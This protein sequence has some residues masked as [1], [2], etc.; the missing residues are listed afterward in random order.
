MFVKNANVLGICAWAQQFVLAQ[1]IMMLAAVVLNPPEFP[2][3]FKS[4]SHGFF[5][6]LFLFRILVFLKI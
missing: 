3:S 5:R 4:S 6:F 1:S 2:Q